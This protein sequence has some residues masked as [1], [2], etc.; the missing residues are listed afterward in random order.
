[1]D[2]RFAEMPLKQADVIE[3]SAVYPIDASIS[4]VANALE[5]FYAVMLSENGQPKAIVTRWDYLRLLT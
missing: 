3:T 1:M 5:N 4:C 2:R